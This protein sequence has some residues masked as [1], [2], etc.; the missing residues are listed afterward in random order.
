M[1][2]SRTLVRPPSQCAHGQAGLRTRKSSS[3]QSTRASIPRCSR[4]CCCSWDLT[5]CSCSPIALSSS[6]VAAAAACA[7]QWVHC[8]DRPA[9]RNLAAFVARCARVPG[10]H[11]GKASLLLPWQGRRRSGWACMRANCAMCAWLPH[12]VARPARQ[13]SAFRSAVW[14]L[15]FLSGAVVA[16]FCTP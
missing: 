13:Q 1:W 7:V 2:R 6:S 15:R 14:H 8:H 9:F 3:A 4:C 16:G 12:R 11:H 10:P 5:S